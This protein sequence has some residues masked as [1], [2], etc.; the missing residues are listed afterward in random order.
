MANC[1][2]GLLSIGSKLT[3]G[4]VLL[5]I[6]SEAAGSDSEGQTQAQATPDLPQVI[7]DLIDV[8]NE[9]LEGNYSAYTAPPTPTVPGVTQTAEP[10][11]Q[12]EPQTKEVVVTPPPTPYWQPI[13]VCALTGVFY[14]PAGTLRLGAADASGCQLLCSENVYC[15]FF[16]FWPD[17]KCNLY[18]GAVKLYNATAACAEESLV[19]CPD[20][21]VLSGPKVCPVGNTSFEETVQAATPVDVGNT[22][23]ANTNAAAAAAEVDGS[24]MNFNLLYAIGGVV[25]VAGIVACVAIRACSGSKSKKGGKNGQKPVPEK[26]KRG[27]ATARVEPEEQQQLLAEDSDQEAPSPTAAPICTQPGLTPRMLSTP[28]LQPQILQAPWSVAQ[29]TGTYVWAPET[30]A[31]PAPAMPMGSALMSNVWYA[32]GGQPIV[33]TGPMYMPVASQEVYYPA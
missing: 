11:A 7:S 22:T 32:M 3:L 17:G 28:Y 8:V 16:S 20:A 24:G 15:K 10:V 14:V 5:A 30:V 23:S 18:D 26:K 9:T 2:Q 29:P 31:A 4:V 1:R 25:L 33:T 21:K 12:A 19:D 27:V 6:F 13:P